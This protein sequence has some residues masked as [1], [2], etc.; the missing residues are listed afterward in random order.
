MIHKGWEYPDWATGHRERIKTTNKVSDRKSK[1]AEREQTN[2]WDVRTRCS[3][4]NCGDEGAV[5]IG[6]SVRANPTP[7]LDACDFLWESECKSFPSALPATVFGGGINVASFSDL[8]LPLDAVPF[9]VAEVRL[10]K[11]SGEEAHEMIAER[12]MSVCWAIPREWRREF[13]TSMSY[14]CM[15]LA[16]QG[17]Y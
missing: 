13:A 4:Y 12:A 11:W 17:R 3:T 6:V 9:I 16:G 7:S 2:Q 1:S 5:E 14:D 8:G 10:R 15:R